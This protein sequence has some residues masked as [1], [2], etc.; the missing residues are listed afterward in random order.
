M[1]KPKEIDFGF[2]H[3]D[4]KIWD[5]NL[6]AEELDL[7][8]LKDNLNI[9]YLEKEGTDD[10]NLTPKEL[11]KNYKNQPSHY[12]RIQSAS[13]DYPIKTS[14]FRLAFHFLFR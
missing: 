11:I 3:V 4:K 13:L 5:L 1:P 10:W 6:P 14:S 9:P 12:A 8:F 2:I 7:S